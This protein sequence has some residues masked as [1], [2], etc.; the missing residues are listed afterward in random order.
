MITAPPHAFTSAS[1]VLHRILD[2]SNVMYTFQHE[3]S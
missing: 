2:N 1:L 3:G